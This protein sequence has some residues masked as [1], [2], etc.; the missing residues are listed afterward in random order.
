MPEE[1]RATVQ[2]GGGVEVEVELDVNIRA[3]V[4]GANGANMQTVAG[5]GA[6]EDWVNA[7]PAWTRLDPANFA[8]VISVFFSIISVGIIVLNVYTLASGQKVM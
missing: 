7:V 8:L 3:T 1:E 6:Q 5:K 4:D 2:R